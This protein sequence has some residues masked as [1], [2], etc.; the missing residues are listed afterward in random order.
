MNQ[1]KA[2]KI[3]IISDSRFPSEATDTQQVV[4]NMAALLDAGANAEIIAPYVFRD[5]FRSNRKM[6]E[7]IRTF[8]NVSGEIRIRRLRI[9]PAVNNPL[10]KILH[11]IFASL[12]TII[13]RYD[14]VYSR[15]PIA[16]VLALLMRRRVI[17]KPTGNSVTI[18]PV[19]YI[20]WPVWP[21]RSGS[22]GSSPTVTYPETP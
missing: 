5:F 13:R 15:N 19:L 10:F 7:R 3:A 12:Y 14:V 6:E 21:A 18:I 2:L 4:K 16:A 17:L 1:N 22:S 20:N 9:L 8:Y 11:G